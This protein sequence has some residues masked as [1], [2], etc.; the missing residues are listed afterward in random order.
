MNIQSFLNY[1]NNGN[2]IVPGTPEHIFM[3]ELSQ[4]AIQITMELNST[5]HAPDE[6]RRIMSRLT[7]RVIPDTF[8]MFPP[9]YTDCGV[10]LHIGENVFFNSGCRFQDQGGIYIGDGA[11]IGHNVVLATIN[12]TT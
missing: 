4:R 8:N 7:G 10:N 2:S 3:C 11:L 6:I 12:H 1:V 9:F 5:Y